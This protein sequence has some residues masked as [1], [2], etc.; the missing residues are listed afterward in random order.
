VH[1]SFAF[2]DGGS[3][4]STTNG[5]IYAAFV[6]PDS[7]RIDVWHAPGEAA[8]FVKLANPF[9]GCSLIGHPRL[10]VGYPALSLGGPNPSL[11]VAA[12]IQSCNTGVLGD[13]P[14]AF[15]QVIINRFHNG[16]WG[17]PRVA[18]NPAVVYPE[19]TLSDRKLR[20]G[21]QFAFDVGTAS[22]NGNDH[23]RM[24][25]TRRDPK[26]SRLYVEGSFCRF[27]LSTSCKPAPEWGSTPGYYSYQ[28]DQFNPNVRSFPGLFT[29]PPAWAGTFISRDKAPSSNTV[30][31]RRGA[32][33]VLPDGSR[34]MVG[35]KLADQGLVCPDN[36]GYW[37]D[38][39][40]LQFI[41]F[42]KGTTTARGIWS[43]LPCSPAASSGRVRPATPS[44]RSRPP[45]AR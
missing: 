37:G 17:T 18:S 23:I 21:P 34:I 30:I 6:A 41:G 28:G 44:D 19:V 20:T 31:I 29:I 24:L 14:G 38:Y 36:R 12:Q 35:F 11:F 27:D 45:I 5:D 39:D 4:A 25:V 13:G 10:R 9:P 2:Y 32:L 15:G 33:A 43:V 8:Q 26:S 3:M 22:S 40:D 1:D 16:Q 42:V 7:D